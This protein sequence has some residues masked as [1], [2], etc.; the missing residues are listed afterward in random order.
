MYLNLKNTQFNSP[1]PHKNLKK[2]EANKWKI[3]IFYDKLFKS[4]RC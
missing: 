2:F 1:K 4:K 3:Y